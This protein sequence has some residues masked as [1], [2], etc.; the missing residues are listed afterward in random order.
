VKNEKCFQ[1]TNIRDAKKGDYEYY[2]LL[3]CD[4]LW[5]DILTKVIM[6]ITVL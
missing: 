1:H 4:V 3:A 2:R 6:K 5:F